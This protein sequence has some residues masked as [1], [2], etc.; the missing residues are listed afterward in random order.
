MKI[1]DASLF[2]Q[3]IAVLG[4]LSACYTTELKRRQNIAAICGEE[5]PDYPILKIRIGTSL[6]V[7][8][9]LVYFLLVSVHILKQADTPQGC[10]SAKINLVASMLLVIVGAMRLYDLSVLGELPLS[11]QV[12]LEDVILPDS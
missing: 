10:L 4:G 12:A 7:F 3:L 6:V 8:A 1:L 11:P 5:I 2:F 9:T